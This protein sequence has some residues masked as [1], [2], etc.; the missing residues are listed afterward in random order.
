MQKIIGTCCLLAGIAL[1]LWGYSL[2]RSATGKWNG[3]LGS[4]PGDK[5]ILLYFAGGTLC[6]FGAAQFFFRRQ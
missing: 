1:F 4:S 6:V 3:A 2:S 5:A